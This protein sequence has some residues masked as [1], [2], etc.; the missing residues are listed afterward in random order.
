MKRKYAFDIHWNKAT[1]W[2][3]ET[4]SFK[5]MIKE[6]EYRWYGIGWHEVILTNKKI[7]LDKLKQAYFEG[8]GP[9]F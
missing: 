4:K 7:S 8:I 3:Q 1:T 2:L 5:Q 6:C 9:K